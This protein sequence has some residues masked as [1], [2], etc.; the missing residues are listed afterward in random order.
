MNKVNAISRI[1]TSCLMTVLFLSSCSKIDNYL[2]GKDNTPEPAELTKITSTLDV[3]SSWTTGAGAGT[4]GVYLEMA[5]A[6]N[7]STIYTADVNGRV[8]AFERKTGD[9][10]WENDLDTDLISGPSVDE[11]SLAVTDKE[12]KII[13][14]DAKTGK[15][16]WSHTTSNEIFSPPTLAEG[17][18]FV[19]TVDGNLYAFDEESGHRQWIYEHGNPSLIMRAGSSPQVLFGA[20]I[21]GF[22]DGKLIGLRADT[23]QILW[24]KTLSMPEGATDVE[25]MADIDAN[26]IVLEGVAY[27]ASYQQNISAL[28]L[29]T[30]EIVWENKKVSAIHNMAADSTTLYVVDTHSTIWAIDRLSGTVLWKQKALENRRLTAPTLVEGDILVVGDSQGFIHW[31]S[32][33]DGQVLTRTRPARS[34]IVLPL[35]ADGQDVYLLTSSGKLIAYRVPEHS[36]SITLPDHSNSMSFNVD[37]S[38]AATTTTTETPHE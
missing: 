35:V 2:L 28:S 31:I 19:K 29:Q 13:V 24:E 10:L 6:V 38:L 12:A 23:G 17:K 4:K 18:V 15:K 33:K 8:M 20:V 22:A 11:T 9:K 37:Q 7:E 5:P 3:T 16:R 1:I 25:R 32:T 21:V 14:L 27:V 30:G 36:S 26:P 34:A